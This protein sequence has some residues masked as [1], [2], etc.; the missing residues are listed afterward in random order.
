MIKYDTVLSL[1]SHIINVMSLNHL[2]SGPSHRLEGV[3]NAVTMTTSPPET[4]RL[5]L[6]GIIIYLV[7]L[8][9]VASQTPSFSATSDTEPVPSLSEECRRKMHPV[10]SYTGG[11][12]KTRS[13]KLFLSLAFTKVKMGVSAFNIFSPNW[14]QASFTTNKTNKP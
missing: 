4:K 8:H 9:L 14:G 12:K 2:S 10:T 7:L 3:P 6:A 11:C 1:N 13:S 5:S